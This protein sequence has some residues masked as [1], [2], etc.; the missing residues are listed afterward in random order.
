MEA[1]VEAVLKEHL[2]Y[3]LDMLEQSFLR[4][5]SEGADELDKLIKNALVETF[6][7]HARNLFE[8]FKQ[9]P[10]SEHTRGIVSAQDLA[11]GYERLKEKS[12]NF[13][14]RVNDQITHLRY[15]RVSKDK[16]NEYEMLRAKEAIEREFKRFQKKLIDP[17]Y[18]TVWTP[19]LPMQPI[20]ASMLPSGAQT[21]AL[22]SVNIFKVV[23]G[24]N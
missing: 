6:W 19:R 20:D 3:E 13:T 22:G 5:H 21:T 12:E 15:E 11:P 8:F 10:S 9:C 24:G 16:F 1:T 14:G 17:D 23:D 18:L 2:P 7:V 4:L